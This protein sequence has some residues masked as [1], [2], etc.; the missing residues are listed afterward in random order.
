MTFFTILILFL[1]FLFVHK[2]YESNFDKLNI[3]LKLSNS[4]RNTTKFILLWNDCYG[5]KYWYHADKDYYD[6]KALHYCSEKRCFITSRRDYKHYYDFDALLF[7]M[8]SQLS[9]IP[10]FRQQK[11]LYIFGNREPPGYLV[12]AVKGMDNFFNLTGKYVDLLEDL[13]HIEQAWAILI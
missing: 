8:P 6:E 11:Q 7:H 2:T 12:R 1:I 10:K 4:E 9:G 3:L 13:F 5:S